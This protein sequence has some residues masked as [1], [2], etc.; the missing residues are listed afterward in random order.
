M[1]TFAES[2][3]SLWAVQKHDKHL[4]REQE[5]IAKGS[6]DL[7][8]EQAK[9]DGSKKKLE[10]E[11]ESLRQ[12]KNKHKELEDELQRLDGRVKQL[13]AQGTEA[14]SEAAAKQ[15]TRIDELETEGF[16]VLGQIG[17]QEDVVAQAEGEFSK[18]EEVLATVTQ[19][20]EE[21]SQA[22]QVQIDEAAAQRTKTAK[23][24]VPELLTVYDEVN[25]RHQGSAICH[26]ED[27]FCGGCQ[28]ELNSQLTMQVRARKEILRCPHCA[29]ILD[30]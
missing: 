8:N 13:E 16:E 9:V 7:A 5:R 3:D 24:V 20:V 21:T 15:R 4:V 27:G 11:R 22:A 19:A 17:E 1:T 18:R 28:G 12:L 26:I 30:A 6:R 25:S 2:L 29:R 10:A 23:L 14:G